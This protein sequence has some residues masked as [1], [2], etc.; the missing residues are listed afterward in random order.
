MKKLIFF[1][2][3]LSIICCCLF[4]CSL[5]ESPPP[6]GEFQRLTPWRNNS[7]LIFRDMKFDSFD[8]LY[9]A[10]QSRTIQYNCCVGL[11]NENRATKAV[12]AHT[13]S[14]IW[15]A[16]TVPRLV[17]YQNGDVLT[18]DFEKN[19]YYL[20]SMTEDEPVTIY[21]TFDDPM[22]EDRQFR[23]SFQVKDSI[24]V[25]QYNTMDKS[26]R[27]EIRIEGKQYAGLYWKTEEEIDYPPI[28]HVAVDYG[29]Y[30]LLLEGGHLSL[31]GETITAQEM[32]EVL[33]RLVIREENLWEPEPVV[34]PAA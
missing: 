4:A 29:N 8:D 26:C 34:N 6:I 22:N 5:I 11:D 12:C 10:I 28:S 15:A 3:L 9:K 24:L 16:G 23:L 2:S 19:E 7:T 13:Y 18:G 14:A 31:S 33:H 21:T 27:F 20:K 1:L 17:A 25:E 30:V 32:C